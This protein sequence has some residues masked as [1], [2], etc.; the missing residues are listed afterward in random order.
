[1]VTSYV[2]VGLVRVAWTE[3]QVI[4]IVYRYAVIPVYNAFLAARKNEYS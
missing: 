2:R 3:R 1:M 4:I